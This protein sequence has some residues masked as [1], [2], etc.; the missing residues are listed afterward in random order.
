MDINTLA[1]KVSELT[2]QVSGLAADVD[3]LKLILIFLAAGTLG[4]SVISGLHF[5]F[6]KKNGN[7][8]PVDK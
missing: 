7:N 1:E 4:N 8:K 6:T 2:A 3:W 5:R